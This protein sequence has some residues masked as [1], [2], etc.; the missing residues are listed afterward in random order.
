MSFDSGTSGLRE[1][2]FYVQGC[3]AS[4]IVLLGSVFASRKYQGPSELRFES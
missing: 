4:K 1:C 3:A 2:A